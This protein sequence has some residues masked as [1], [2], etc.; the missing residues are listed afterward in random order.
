M[1]PVVISYLTGFPS[2]VHVHSHGTCG[3]IHQEQK[4]QLCAGQIDS[5]C[6]MKGKEEGR[7]M[8]FR[9]TKK[10]INITRQTRF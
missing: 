2:A 8:L 9:R 6:L 7:A 4:L 5:R 1:L 3:R 10:K